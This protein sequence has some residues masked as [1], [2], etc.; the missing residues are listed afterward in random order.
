MLDWMTVETIDQLAVQY[1]SLGLFVGF[2]IT[3]LEAFLPFLP[4]VLFIAVNVTAY[5][6]LWG[7]ILS[8][9]GTLFGSFAVFLLVRKFGRARIMRKWVEKRQVQRLIRWV[10][11]AGISPLLVLL[12]FPFTPGILVNI[13]AGLSSIKKKYY[14]ITLFVSKCAMVFLLTFIVQDISELIRNPIK[15]IIVSIVLILLWVFGKLFE[16]TINKRVER[17]LRNNSIKGKN[18]S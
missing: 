10:N 9:L 13:V 14:F 8:W 15:L 5:G 18:I 12:C 2:L 7:F 6:L 16:R 4:L 11:M 3:F 1:R 17:D